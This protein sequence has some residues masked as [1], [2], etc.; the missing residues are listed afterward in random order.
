MIDF[1]QN[2]VRMEKRQNLGG[3]E[4]ILTHFLG[5]ALF[6]VQSKDWF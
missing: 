1:V 2:F 5:I 4:V 6:S 3:M